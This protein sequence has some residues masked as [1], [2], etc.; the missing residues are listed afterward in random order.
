MRLTE[1]DHFSHPHRLHLES[2]EAPYRCDGCKEEGFGRCYQCPYEDCNF[3]LHEECGNASLSISHPY[4][5]TCNLK[6]HQKNP[7]SKDRYCDACGMDING[8]VYQCSHKDA[9]DLHPCCAKL[10]KA[11]SNN[12]VEIYLSKEVRSK[13]LRC[14]RKV[15]ANGVKGW[16]YVSSCGKYCYHVACVRE[17]ILEDWR[18]GS[19]GLELQNI[20]SSRE[21]VVPS[22]ESSWRKNARKLWLIVKLAVSVIFGDPVTLIAS[23]IQAL[24][25]N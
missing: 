8:F 14:E 11:L 7:T 22:G 5:K 6:F 20:S 13:C 23:L 4:L 16:S 15:I 18:R 17:A 12:G 3:H 2:T 21:V 24:S 19:N 9:H 1:I 10:P 25:S